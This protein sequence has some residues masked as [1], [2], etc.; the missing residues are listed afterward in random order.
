MA[1]E[2]YRRKRDFEKTPE[3]PP[4]RVRLKSDKLSYLIQKHDATRL[5]YDF[6]LELDG[7]LLSWAVTKGPSVNPEDKRLAVRTEDHPLS[8]GSF[9][10][11]IPKG[12]YGGGT[13]MLWDTGTWEP[14]GEPHDG[15][16]KG[17]LS[18][19]LH[20]KRLK[21][22]WDLIRM[23]GKDEKRENWLLIKGDDKFANKRANGDA[24]KDHSASV[25]TGRSME[26]IAAGDP[27]TK[28]NVETLLKQYPEVQLATLVDGVPTG[29]AW[30]HEIKYDGYRL[31]GYLAA[32]EVRLLTRNGNDWTHRF[33]SIQAA[34]AK[35]DAQQ[36]VIDM[37]A[38]VLDAQG[39]SSFQNLQHALGGGGGS[40]RITAFAF[41]LLHLNGEDLRGLPLTER[42]EALKSLL[43]GHNKSA[44]RYSDHIEGQGKE[45]FA[46]ACE[47]G[48]EGIIAKKADAPYRTGRQKDWLKIKCSLRQEFIIVGYSEARTGE[49][50]LG[51]LYLGY[52][53]G[54]SL[55][56]AGKVGTGFTMKSA[57]ELT[58]AFE[59]ISVEKPVFS[60]EEAAGVAAGEYRSIHWVKPVMLCEVAFTEW[61]SDGRIRHPSFQGLRED[62]DAKDV[63]QETPAKKSS[64]KQQG[65]VVKGITITNS[66]RVISEVGKVTKGELAEY[67]AAVAPLILP[68]IAGRPISLLRCP[69]GI[70]G[71]CFFQRNPGK[72]LGADI[73]PFEFHHKGKKYE[74]LYIEDEK[75][76]IELAQMGAIEIHP[77]GAPVKSIDYPDRMI[78]DLD[79]SPEVPFEAVKLAAQDLKQ[80]LKRKGLE[81]SLKCTGG[82]GL[83]VTVPL[84]GKDKWAEV[85]AFA[86]GLA[87]EMV[88]QVPDAY[89][90]T[91]A[92]VQRTGKIFIDY[93]RND[94]TATSI[95]DY[96]ARA[97]P[98]IP[99]ALPLDWKELKSLESA[100]QFT[101]KDIAQRLKKKA[102]L[103]PDPQ[104]LP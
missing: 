78:F 93:F 77:W 9:E 99:I 89:V 58:K 37:E 13:V 18:F 5:H 15:L 38:V 35:L 82:K 11:T 47:S 84:A 29:D 98:G 33:G 70:D 27:K 53:K 69:S 49:R 87:E 44:I 28:R 45:M 91:M 22:K 23:R 86:G 100:N 65:L 96:S 63:K 59:P 90:A 88:A 41:D 92:K 102:P 34:L 68:E 32:G 30:V 26:E 64:A 62:K 83:H 4:G 8:Y 17:H 66:D 73:K 20:G 7:V 52:R 21:G 46:K 36:A 19:V 85:K 48:L 81:S 76:L 14:V 39:K 55:H 16:K 1:L 71:E 12:E 97:R 2:E 75:G 24:L 61:T 104:R 54:T 6:R 95:A 10:G 51:A 67:Y 42:K 80:R 3:P 43:K 101:V 79:P 72:G 94:Y 57:Q 60:R 25:K 50:A 74:Y 103:A 56:Y 40:E 31:L